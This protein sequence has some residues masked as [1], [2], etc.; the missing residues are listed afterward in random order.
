MRSCF[1]EKLLK[2]FKDYA[3]GQ[4]PTHYYHRM[5]ANLAGLLDGMQA[6]VVAESAKTAEMIYN[7]TGWLPLDGECMTGCY[8]FEPEGLKCFSWFTNDELVFA[9]YIDQL[10]TNVSATVLNA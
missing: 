8:G 5:L 2:Y 7:M 4:Y 9:T 6:M 1:D 10:V 3:R